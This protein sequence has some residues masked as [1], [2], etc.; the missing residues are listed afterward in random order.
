MCILWKR[1]LEIVI[2]E[3]WMRRSVPEVAKEM[4]RIAKTARTTNG[5]SS[6]PTAQEK[7]TTPRSRSSGSSVEWSASWTYGEFQR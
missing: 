5:T 7:A 3:S 6:V 1:F 4:A 2:Y